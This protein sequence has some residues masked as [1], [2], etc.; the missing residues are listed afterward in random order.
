[1]P[2]WKKVIVSGSSANLSNLNV[3]NNVAAS[4]FSGDGSNLTFNGTDIVSGSSQVNITNLNGYSAFSASVEASITA[5]TPT[6]TS[7]RQSITG[8]SSYTVT[9]S[10]NETFCQISVFDNNNELTLPASVISVNSNN[11]SLSFDETFTGTVVVK[12]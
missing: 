10:L 8:A 7:Y 1:M 5:Q 4:S 6:S 9:H 3:T 12:K 11:V 2:N